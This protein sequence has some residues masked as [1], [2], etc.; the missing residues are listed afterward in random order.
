MKLSI[1]IPT[2]TQRVSDCFPFVV[3]QLN[4]QIEDRQDIEIIGFLDNI[5]RTVG[6]KRQDLLNLAQG[7]YLVYFDDDD[8]PS[9]DY[10]S[11]IMHVLDNEN[12]DS[13]VFKVQYHNVRKGRG[14]LCEYDK[15]YTKRG[16]C[17]DGVWRGPPAHIHVVKTEIAKSVRWLE[18][19]TGSQWN[20]DVVWADEVS[21]KIKTQSKID[22]VLYYY[23]FDPTISETL[24]RNQQEEI[25]Q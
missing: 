19:P 16:V 8:T 10:I 13:V 22:K 1:L 23:N 20:I 11:S 17:E 24:K 14:F 12:V 2:I 21:S 9:V 25:L 5:K 3:Q 7:E 18:R 15:S 6:V 4:V